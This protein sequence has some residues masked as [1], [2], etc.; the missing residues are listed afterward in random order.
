MSFWFWL[1]ESCFRFSG[2]E[3]MRSVR[4]QQKF[5][6]QPDGMFVAEQFAVVIV[7]LQPDLGELAEIK[8]EV[9]RDARSPA[10]EHIVVVERARISV[11][12]FAAQTG[13]PARFE[14]PK[15]LRVESPVLQHLGRKR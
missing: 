10:A 15:R 11:G 1:V 7:V 12:I 3:F 14:T 2:L 6:L 8:R 9:R 5:E 4:A 13:D